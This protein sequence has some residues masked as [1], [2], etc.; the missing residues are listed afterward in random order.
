MRE[1]FPEPTAPTT[2]INRP[3]FTSKLILT[4]THTQNM[5]FTLVLSH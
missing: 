5:L 4:N 3:G 1:D 2:A